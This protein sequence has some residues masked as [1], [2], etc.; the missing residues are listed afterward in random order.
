MNKYRFTTLILLTCALSA[1]A[2]KPNIILIMAD[3]LGWVETGAYGQKKIK[4]PHIDR[5][6]QRGIRF[7]QFY[8][9][10]AVCAPTRDNIMT[11]RHGGHAT[12][13]N[14]YEV[15]NPNNDQDPYIWGG[16]FPLPK[17]VITIAEVLKKEGYATGAFGKWG[18]GALGSEG[19][20]LK[21]GFD[22]YYGF[23]CQRH[24][25][26]LYPKYIVDDSKNVILKG[27]TR[28]HTG[29]QYGPQLIADELIKFIH[30]KKDRPFFIYYPTL[31]PHL[32]LQVPEQYMEQYL[33]KW[34]DEPYT[35]KSY[36]P[37]DTPKAAYAGM[38]SFL[39]EQVGR[40]NTVLSDLG[41]ADN[42]VILFTSDNGTTH[43][44]AQVDYE[45][46][47]SVGELRGLK[48]SLHEGGIR[49]PLIVTW[50]ERIKLGRTSDHISAHYDLLAT[51]A[52]IA[53][54]DAPETD[55]ISILPTI[56]G[57]TKKQKTHDYLFWDF[58]GYGAQLAVRMG[59]WKAIKKDL[60][61]N[62][63]APLELYHLGKDISESND[64]A[65]KFPEIAEK[66]E[67]IMRDARSIP[68]EPR[69]RFGVYGD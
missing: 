55:G 21:Q 10:S 61:K 24:A 53:G 1:F 51:L 16:Q 3:D 14:N 54:A 5:L 68:E 31:I 42:T 67:K 26:N 2:G 29:E 66:M 7:T 17:E 57:K 63:D 11:G 69:F 13:R 44:G 27:N 64:V 20:P 8:S 45:F 60:K 49:V 39:D 34:D 12:V 28:G 38:I 25:H 56:L 65:A 22:R 30:E 18:L 62:K 33:G 40:I 58:A 4:T 43:L 36:Q 37:H 46:F 41:L 32:P 52:D 23:N 9:G 59:P 35:G 48:G 19:D 6:A 50:P 47:G 15:K